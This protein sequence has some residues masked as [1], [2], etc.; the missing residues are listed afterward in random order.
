MADILNQDIINAIRGLYQGPNRVTDSAVN[1]KLTS[2][3]S[4][5]QAILNKL[6]TVLNVKATDT[7]AEL[8]AIKNRLL[9]TLNVKDADALA[10]L[11]ALEAELQAIKA[12]LN[13]V[14]DVQL[15]GSLVEIPVDHLNR[16]DLIGAGTVRYF[17]VGIGTASFVSP[18]DVSKY[19]T[20]Y[21]KVRN[22]HNYPVNLVLFMYKTLNP[23]VG[24]GGTRFASIFNESLPA[25]TEKVYHGG[26]YPL[27]NLPAIGYALQ[28]SSLPTDATG[29]FDVTY[30]GGAL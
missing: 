25:G 20:K 5:L 28:A 11:T 29:D 30:F 15:M 6:G 17:A 2:A 10:R 8:A 14:L 24:A 9:A 12:R 7:D 27:F 16:T 19:K 23:G 18:I 13:G 22:G 21:L 3:I 1:S 26:E 4:E